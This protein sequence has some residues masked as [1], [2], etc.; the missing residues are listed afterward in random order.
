MKRF[1]NKYFYVEKN[2]DT[3]GAVAMLMFALF[4]LAM[5]LVFENIASNEKKNKDHQLIQCREI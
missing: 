4:M 2:F 3:F 5:L 1:L